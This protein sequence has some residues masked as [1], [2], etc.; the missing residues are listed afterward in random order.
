[1]ALLPGDENITHLYKYIPINENTIG[2]LEE[3]ELYFSFPS[4][5]N[6]PFDCKVEMIFNGTKEDWERWINSQP[7]TY[8]E[9]QHLLN[10][11]ESINYDSSRF[12][13]YQNTHDTKSIILFCLSE[14]NDH[15]LMWSHYADNHIGICIGFK[16]KIEGNSLGLQFDDQYL[17]FPLTGVSKGFLPVSKVK[18]S[19]KMPS[20]YNRLKYDDSTLQEFLK[21]KHKDW[22][23]ERERR[24][25]YPY[26]YVNKQNIKFDKSILG[27]IIFGVKT[28]NSEKYK[29]I[30]VVKKN[31]IDQGFD[32]KFYQAKYKQHVYGLDIIDMNID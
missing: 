16:T 19:M 30:N 6:D 15:I 14:I 7:I 23:Y 10:Y 22:E 32:V 27:Q 5:F 9:K 8:S 20:A 18:Y 29:I 4:D 28:S 11:L 25:I 21:T 24:I 13:S 12:V 31:Y 2:L 26:R 3:N 17:K 1:M